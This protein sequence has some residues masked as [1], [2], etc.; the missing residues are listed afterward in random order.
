MPSNSCGGG[1]ADEPWIAHTSEGLRVLLK[2]IVSLVQQF[3]Y[4][5]ALFI[6]LQPRVAVVPKG[7]VSVYSCR[8]GFSA[9][10]GPDGFETT[11]PEET[12]RNYC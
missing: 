5:A 9:S 12:Q 2:R 1:V 10:I 3:A 7:Q 8:A 4:R 6:T 11:G